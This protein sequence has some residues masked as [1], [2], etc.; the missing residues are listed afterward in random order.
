MSADTSNAVDVRRMMD[1]FQ[2]GV[3]NL[4]EI[5]SLILPPVTLL[6][7]KKLSRSAAD[8][9]HME[10]SLWA[11]IIYDFALAHR[12]RNIRRAHLFGALTPLYLG[13]VASY[14]VAI[15]RTG[16]AS[17][18]GTSGT[19][20]TRIRSG[21]TLSRIPLALAGSFPSLT[22]VEQEYVMWTQVH[23]ALQESLHRAV[24][25]VA[26]LLPGVLALIV[27]L[28]VS[29]FI[30]WLL[31]LHR[32][33]HSAGHRVRSPRGKMGNRRCLRNGPPPI[34]PSSW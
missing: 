26:T 15:N 23:Q 25:K 28:I 3:S 16:I 31:A 33:P 7:L 13:W 4:R 1:A 30:G 8:D 21:E 18:R 6:E 17:S 27:A 14:A 12:L 2:L 34:L 11:R 20:G 24:F 5:W 9:F 22:G 19:T 10:D 29:I 32:P